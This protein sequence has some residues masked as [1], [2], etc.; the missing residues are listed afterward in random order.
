MSETALLTLAE[1]KLRSTMP[2]EDVDALETAYPGFL[3]ARLVIHTAWIHARLKKRYAVPFV[4]SIPEIARGWLTHL[5][6]YDAYMRRGYNPGSQEDGQIKLDADMA[7]AEVKEAADSNEGLFDLPLR[8]DSPSASGISKGG[9][10]G[11]SE[12]SPYVAFDLQRDTGR[13]EDRTRSGT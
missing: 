8:A 11:Y 4:E 1:F 9:P 13:G 7:R 10:F 2:P 3:L 12:Q 6:T 5:V